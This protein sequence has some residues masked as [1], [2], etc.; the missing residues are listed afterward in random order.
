MLAWRE[1]FILSGFVLLWCGP[2]RSEHGATSSLRPKVSS[3]ASECS[4][5]KFEDTFGL[6]KLA[7][8]N[9]SSAART[10]HPLLPI[11]TL[12]EK[13]YGGGG[14]GASWSYDVAAGRRYQAPDDRVFRWAVSDSLSCFLDKHTDSSDFLSNLLTQV[15]L[16]DQIQPNGG[17]LKT[18][19]KAQPE[20]LETFRKMGELFEKLKA[21]LSQQQGKKDFEDFFQAFFKQIKK[22]EQS[23]LSSKPQLELHPDFVRQIEKLRKEASPE[24]ASFVKDFS[25]S[26]E[27]D[28]WLHPILA[29]H[30]RKA[31]KDPAFSLKPNENM[32]P[33]QAFD[34]GR[35]FQRIFRGASV[36]GDLKGPSPTDPLATQGRVVGQQIS[37]PQ[38]TNLLGAEL[39][40]LAA[41]LPSDERGRQAMLQDTAQRLSRSLNDY[42]TELGGSFS[43]EHLAL[44]DA[45]Q[46]ALARLTNDRDSANSASTLQGEGARNR[47]ETDRTIL[48]P[49]R[50]KLESE[51]SGHKYP[52]SLAA[53]EKV[54]VYPESM[55]E[56]IQWLTRRMEPKALSRGAQGNLEG[57]LQTG[58]TQHLFDLLFQDRNAF[59]GALGFISAAKEASKG[60]QALL[61]ATSLLTKLS[62]QSLKPNSKWNEEYAYARSLLKDSISKLS[63]DALREKDRDAH[64]LAL[65]LLDE[66]GLKNVTDRDTKAADS[67]LPSVLYQELNAEQ[68]ALSE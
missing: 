38:I 49:L 20:E 66:I 59:Q 32:T 46:T 29:N 4:Q 1:L 11:R 26:P 43:P 37:S 47:N 56:L 19:G 16:L 5:S 52:I 31:L 34:L 53:I 58:E 42:Q 44:R 36:S 27:F 24:L 14:M 55:K 13:R 30:F 57:F 50:T 23:L 35:E 51:L 12:T 15:T 63:H 64:L 9:K 10:A 18:D 61:R 3:R 2:V 21:E 17:K 33:A 45:T 28:Y 67:Y 48:N 41:R 7:D 6:N 39:D 22:T 40:H 68:I 65:R 54:S 62:A 25:E 60:D 8:A